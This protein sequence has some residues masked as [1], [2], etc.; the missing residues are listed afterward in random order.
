MEAASAAGAPAGVASS[1]CFLNRASS[2]MGASEQVVSAECPRKRWAMEWLE[3]QGSL[4][5][6]SCSCHSVVKIYQGPSLARV[7]RRTPS[8]AKD[9]LIF[10]L[11]AAHVPCHRA[12]AA[13][14]LA[15]REVVGAVSHQ[16]LTRLRARALAA[17]GI[18]PAAPLPSLSHFI[19]SPTLFLNC[20]PTYREWQTAPQHLRRGRRSISPPDGVP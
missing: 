3:S 8:D 14:S 1:G 4:Y 10:K 5:L 9:A 11:P 12:R 15:E 6:R 20:S 18:T 19:C 16:C 13:L 2:D 7:R 17:N